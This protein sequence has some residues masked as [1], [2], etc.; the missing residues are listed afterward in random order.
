MRE[1]LCLVWQFGGVA[2]FIYF[3]MMRNWPTRKLP[4][5]SLLVRDGK[6]LNVWPIF[7]LA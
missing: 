6:S 2:V 3:A 7:R 1:L 5:I 4:C